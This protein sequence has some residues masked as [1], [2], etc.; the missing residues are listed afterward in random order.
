MYIGKFGFVILLILSYLMTFAQR[1]TL[2]T[3]SGDKLVGELKSLRL[4]VLTFDT[5]YADS[6][7]K[8]EWADVDGII[9]NS[10]LLIF[11][12]DGDRYTGSIHSLPGQPRLVRVLTKTGSITMTLEDIVEITSLKK[13][14]VERIN[15]WLDAGFSYTKANHNQQLSVDGKVK[16]QANK[17]SLSGDFSKVGTYQDNVDK[18]SRTDGNSMFNYTI[19]GKSFAFAGI[20][21]LQN[22]EQKLDLRTTGKVGLGYY[23]FRT[24]HFYFGSGIGMATSKESYGGDSPSTDNSLEGLVST[25]FNAYDIGDLTTSLKF[26]M[27]PSFTNKG[28]IRLDTDFYIKY[29][30]PFDFYIKLS[31]TH[32]YDSQPLIDVSNSDFIFKTSV[33]WEWD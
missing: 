7:F 25:E 3:L 29:D 28:R 24:N 9:V 20:E 30:L 10:T 2:Y 31:Y 26:S 11:T 15:I 13:N 8:I 16:Y 21:F 22:S 6:E 1:D 19:L 23:F 32:N 27:F 14:F 4:S 18:T 33:G 17:W 5:E 12:D